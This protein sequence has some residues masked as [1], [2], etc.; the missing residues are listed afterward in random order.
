MVRNK[1]GGKKA[2]N[3]ANLGF[4]QKLWQAADKLRGHMDAAEYKHV[5]LGLIFLKYISDAF[6]ERQAEES[7]TATTA[8][9]PV[10]T[11]AQRLRSGVIPTARRRSEIA[12]TAAS[13]PESVSRFSRFRSV[14]M[15]ETCW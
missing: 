7:P 4:E 3:G 2:N 10:R 1:S 11:S 12:A 8:N 5:V 15:S 13:R 6:Q 14:R 9:M